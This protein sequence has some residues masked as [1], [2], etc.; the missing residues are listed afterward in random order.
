MY[1]EFSTCGFAAKSQEVKSFQETILTGMLIWNLQY[2]RRDIF[3]CA[4]HGKKTMLF[5]LFLTVR[6]QHFFFPN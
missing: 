4:F 3:L 5:S 6:K 1:K 2:M